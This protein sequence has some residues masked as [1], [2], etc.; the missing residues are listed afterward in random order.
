MLRGL[1]LQHPFLD[2]R[3]P[4]IN[5]DFVTVETGTGAVHIAPGHG[6][7]DF[8]AGLA[9]DLP[10]ENPVGGNGVYLPSTELFAGKHIKAAGSEIIELLDETGRLLQQNTFNH[11]YPHC[12]RHHTPLIFQGHTAVV[13]Q[14]RSEWPAH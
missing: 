3:V 10:L 14:P 7:D 6:Q 11:S 5:T 9:N 12:W 1:E 4:V 8:V 13:C 2:R